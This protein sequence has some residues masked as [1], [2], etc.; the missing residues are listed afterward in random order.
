MT[1]T[2]EAN[3]WCVQGRLPAQ[4]VIAFRG[5]RRV[6]RRFVFHVT[7]KPGRTVWMALAPLICGYLENTKGLNAEAEA[8]PHIPRAY[9]R[10]GGSGGKG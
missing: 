1:G 8:P 7:E 10:R 4:D 3:Q 9:G 2:K 6:W 5:D